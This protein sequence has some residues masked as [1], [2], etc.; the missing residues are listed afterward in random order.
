MPWM[1]TRWPGGS[2]SGQILG[3]AAAHKLHGGR[4]VQHSGTSLARHTHTHIWEIWALCEP[5][6]VG[7]TLR[8]VGV[9]GAL[10]RRDGGDDTGAKE[11][12][13]EVSR[14]RWARDRAL[15][16]PRVPSQPTA[17]GAGLEPTTKRAC[18]SSDHGHA[19]TKGAH[20]G[21]QRSRGCS[22]GVPRGTLGFLRS[23]PGTSCQ[24]SACSSAAC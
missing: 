13:R 11:A 24:M 4:L 7:R 9:S 12:I 10:G 3:P 2:C 6:P 23:R 1:R 18:V 15:G 17:G 21:G 5:Q 14:A 22:P 8:T 16:G 20:R 19:A